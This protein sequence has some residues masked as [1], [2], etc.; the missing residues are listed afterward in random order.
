MRERARS[1]SKGNHSG[2]KKETNDQKGFV[3]FL[4][5][6]TRFF[7]ASVRGTRVFRLYSTKNYVQL[8]TDFFTEKEKKRVCFRASFLSISYGTGTPESPPNRQ[9]YCNCGEMYHS[10]VPVHSVILERLPGS[11]Q[12]EGVYRPGDFLFSSKLISKIVLDVHQM[13]T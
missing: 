9:A 7:C 12:R 5:V 6:T 4:M 1:A 2:T 13:H 11:F 3:H 8:S 10:P